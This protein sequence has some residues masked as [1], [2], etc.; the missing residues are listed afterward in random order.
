LEGFSF[1]RRVSCNH[2]LCHSSAP[3]FV[4]SLGIMN[5]LVGILYCP[6]EE[7]TYR[8]MGKMHEE[9]HGRNLYSALNFIRMIKSRRMRWVGHVACTGYMIRARWY[10]SIRN[11]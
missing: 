11:V 4:M 2:H 5:N 6:W 3:I 10:E 1:Y 9:L 7:G 8:T